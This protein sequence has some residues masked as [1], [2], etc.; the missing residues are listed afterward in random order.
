MRLSRRMSRRRESYFRE[1]P[2]RTVRQQGKKVSCFQKKLKDG[3]GYM[4]SMKDP[5]E[6]FFL[7]IRNGN[8]KSPTYPRLP[9]MTLSLGSLAEASSTPGEPG[10][11]ACEILDQSNSDFAKHGG[12]IHTNIP[13]KFNS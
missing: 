13:E 12:N 10:P 5:N 6:V 1:G 9:A 11:S 3:F 2:N 4:T 8:T 7:C